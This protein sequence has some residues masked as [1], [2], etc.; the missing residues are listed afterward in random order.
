MTQA[1]QLQSR[2][3]LIKLLIYKPTKME[4]KFKTGDLVQLKTGGQVWIVDDYIDK[5]TRNYSGF[6]KSD[7]EV[8]CFFTNDKGEK[9][10]QVF[11]QD[12]LEP[13]K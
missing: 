6:E 4:N 12:T 3:C 7:T 2:E 11:H 10:S 13:A 5:V 8:R 1:G 9:I